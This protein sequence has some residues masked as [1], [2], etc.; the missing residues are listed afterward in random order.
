LLYFIDSTDFGR[1]P[2]EPIMQC[3]FFYYTFQTLTKMEVA[4]I[5]YDIGPIEQQCL[6]NLSVRFDS[7]IKIW[8]VFATTK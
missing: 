1:T 3:R 5:G 8:D 7:S 6:D 2:K 4:P